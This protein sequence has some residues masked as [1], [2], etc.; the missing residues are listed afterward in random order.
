MTVQAWHIMRDKISVGPDTPTQEVAHKIISSGLPAIPVVS[1][2]ME[3]LGVANEHAILGAIRQ[4]LDLQ[5]IS[6]ASIM[7]KSPVTAD[8]TTSTDD[9]IQMM[10]VHNCCSVITIMNNGKYAGAV[11]RHM[12]MDVY[13]SPRYARFAQAESK[14]PFVCL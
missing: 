2:T 1:E 5:E 9:L 13:T 3:V 8:I 11:S 12:L 4:G 10:L 14:A 7:I 6:A